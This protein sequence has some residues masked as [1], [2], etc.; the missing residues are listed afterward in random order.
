MKKNSKEYEEILYELAEQACD[1]T[2][3]HDPW[4]Q[5]WKLGALNT[6][7]FF[8]C[9][10]VTDKSGSAFGQVAE[11]IARSVISGD[12]DISSF[13]GISVGGDAERTNQTTNAV[14]DRSFDD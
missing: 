12:F 6:V 2:A 14:P 11:T 3:K 4:K 13:G 5:L 7:L 10:F 1:T 9:Q 8:I